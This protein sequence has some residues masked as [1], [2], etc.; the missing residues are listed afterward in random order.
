MP[1]VKLPVTKPI[2]V[3]ATRVGG[4]GIGQGYLQDLLRKAT[5]TTNTIEIIDMFKIL[6]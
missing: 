3:Q 1:A 2:K 4:I 6:S 5:T